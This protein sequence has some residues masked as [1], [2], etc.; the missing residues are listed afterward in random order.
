MDKKQQ[1]KHEE[2][3]WSTEERLE[4][5]EYAM[6]DKRAS[7]Y[8]SAMYGIECLINFVENERLEDKQGNDFDEIIRRLERIKAVLRS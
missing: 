5:L 7:N 2:L 1:R 8:Y 3:R 4:A 6:R